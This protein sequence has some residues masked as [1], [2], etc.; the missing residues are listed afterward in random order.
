LET[1]IFDYNGK[2][3]CLKHFMEE[4]VYNFKRVKPENIE[5]FMEEYLIW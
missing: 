1:D 5:D 2:V 4:I 3:F